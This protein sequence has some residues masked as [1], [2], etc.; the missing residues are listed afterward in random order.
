MDLR[1]AK[2]RH[3][4]SAGSDRS[5]EHHPLMRGPT[6][7]VSGLEINVLRTPGRSCCPLGPRFHS[8]N[9][10]SNKPASQVD[11]D[12]SPYMR[13]VNQWSS[14]TIGPLFL[15]VAGLSLLLH[16]GDRTAEASEAVDDARPIIY[17]IQAGYPIL[18]RTACL[19]HENRTPCWVRLPYKHRLLP[20]NIERCQRVKNAMS[21]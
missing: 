13:F 11:L 8:W 10:M 6:V 14:V 18:L 21:D 3:L 4:A 20:R 12:R 15:A 7:A 17:I 5:R 19:K 1:A 16:P 2:G 9:R